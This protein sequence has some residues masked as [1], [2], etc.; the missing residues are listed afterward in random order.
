MAPPV[1]GQLHASLSSLSSIDVQLQFACLQ[2]ILAG[3]C[4]A[5]Y[6]ERKHL[7]LSLLFVSLIVFASAKVQ[8]AVAREYGVDEFVKQMTATYA[9]LTDMLF[10]SAAVS[11]ELPEVSEE[12]FTVT[13]IGCAVAIF[14]VVAT[15]LTFYV[16]TM[17]NALNM[18][19]VCILFYTTGEKYGQNAPQTK[20]ALWIAGVAYLVLQM[21]YE[22]FGQNP[23]FVFAVSAV[24][25][26]YMTTLL[27]MFAN[28]EKAATQGTLRVG[29]DSL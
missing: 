15:G 13:N 16:S 8:I 28:A 11:L 18:A 19:S 6:R 25:V 22:G 10:L 17:F 3:Y 5:L 7:S 20:Q 23:L 14:G 2:I 21:L 24:N 26:L 29:S 12:T 4:F 27:A 9:V 1:E